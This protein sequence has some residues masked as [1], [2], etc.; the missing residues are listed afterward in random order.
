MGSE[1][2]SEESV[3]ISHLEDIILTG[4]VGGE[5]TGDSLRPHGEV[6]TGIE[7]HNGFACR[8]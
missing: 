3:A 4:T 6:L 2:S 8:S 5:G 1:T 7:H